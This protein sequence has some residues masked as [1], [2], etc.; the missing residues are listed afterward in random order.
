MKHHASPCSFSFSSTLLGSNHYPKVSIYYF[1]KCLNFYYISIHAQTI[2]NIICRSR[3]LYEW[4]HTVYIVMNFWLNCFKKLLWR[5][6][7]TCKSKKN[8][9]I[10]TPTYSSS[11]LLS[12]LIISKYIEIISIPNPLNHPAALPQLLWNKSY[13]CKTFNGLVSIRDGFFPKEKPK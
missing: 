10:K 4:H 9:I 5:V 3:T 11:S 12:N 7:N 2:H 8:V 1:Y 6:S 13:T